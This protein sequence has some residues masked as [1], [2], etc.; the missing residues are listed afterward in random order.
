MNAKLVENYARKLRMIAFGEITE[1]MAR[2]DKDSE[3]YKEALKVR[4]QRRQ[5]DLYEYFDKYYRMFNDSK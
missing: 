5:T 1:G 3:E 2:F 4:E